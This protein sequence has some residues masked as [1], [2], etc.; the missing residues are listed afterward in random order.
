MDIVIIIGAVILTVI[1]NAYYLL[2][3]PRG[4]RLPLI[5]EFHAATHWKFYRTHRRQQ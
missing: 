5:T 3:K 1:I 4:I 2:H